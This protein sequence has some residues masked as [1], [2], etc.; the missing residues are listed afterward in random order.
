M[1]ESEQYSFPLLNWVRFPSI[2]ID[3]KQKKSVGLEEN[4]TNFEFLQSLSRQALSK[5]GFVN[6]KRYNDR[7]EFELNL[8][9]KLGFTDYFL[10][11]WKVINKM[12]EL[13]A[14][15]DYGRV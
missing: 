7:L 12:K 5:T 9:N 2:E 14:F 11:E 1:F 10:L 3:K 15:L 4:A 6:D 13:N 8:V